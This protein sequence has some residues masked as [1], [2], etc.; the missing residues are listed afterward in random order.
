MSNIKY[1][2]ANAKLLQKA[3]AVKFGWL[4][5]ESDGRWFWLAK[6]PRWYLIGMWATNSAEDYHYVHLTKLPKRRWQ[7]AQNSL[8]RVNGKGLAWFDER[9]D[10]VVGSKEDTND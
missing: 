1:R 2:I 6:K 10:F 8:I 5:M 3:S 7:F 4:A 9:P